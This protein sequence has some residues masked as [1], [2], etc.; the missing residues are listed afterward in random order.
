MV[1]FLDFRNQFI[2]LGC[3]CLNNIRAVYPGF[4]FTEDT[5]EKHYRL[6]SANYVGN[7]VFS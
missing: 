1:G 4:H 5:P 7:R 6:H 3:F 2:E